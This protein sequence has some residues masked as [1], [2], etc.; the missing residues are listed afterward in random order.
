MRTYK[1]LLSLMLL[2]FLAS[3]SNISLKK[4]A[5]RLIP[6]RL[7][8]LGFKITAP[9]KKVKDIDSAPKGKIL[10]DEILKREI[11]AKKFFFQY[12]NTYYKDIEL[13]DV[14]INSVKWQKGLKISESDLKL[15]HEKYA[16]DGLLFG[17]IPWYGKTNLMWP[18]IGFTADIAIETVIIGVVT[19]WNGPIILAN[20]SWEVLT[21]GPIWFGGAW[22]FG[23]AYKPVTIETKLVTFKDG[24]HE[25]KEEFDVTKSRHM[26]EKFP[27]KE[28]NKIENQL[29]A[30]MK[31]ALKNIAI[32][33]NED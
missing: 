24:I 17:E 18:I 25:H 12:F 2:I 30:S 33:I 8:V 3:C 4:K 13:V 21:N 19:K 10:Q 5:S 7:G 9:I 32:E 28:R 31:K 14:P 27:E 1:P 23:Q 16:L 6:L 26:L 11:E 22:L 15:L 20:L 29:D